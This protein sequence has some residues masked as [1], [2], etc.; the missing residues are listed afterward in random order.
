MA[1]AQEERS[2]RSVQDDN[3]RGDICWTE[4]CEGIARRM[5]KYLEDSEVT[6]VSTRELEE[7][8]LSPHESR[9]NSVRIARQARNEKR[10][11]CFRFSEEEKS[12]SSSLVRRDGMNNDAQ[13]GSGAFTRKTRSSDRSDG[14][15]EG[16]AEDSTRRLSGAD[17]R[18]VDRDWRSRGQKKLWRSYKRSTS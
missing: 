3:D 2:Q 13:G 4:A 6:K 1:Q 10:K 18:G 8:V 5:L 14:E 12:K 9:I 16:R 11:S 15:Q 17:L 7:Q